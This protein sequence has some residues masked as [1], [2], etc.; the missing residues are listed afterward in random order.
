VAIARKNAGTDI[1]PAVAQ[2]TIDNLRSARIKADYSKY[3]AGFTTFGI[4]RELKG[5]LER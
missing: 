2:A 1:Q 3:A 4:S 5:F